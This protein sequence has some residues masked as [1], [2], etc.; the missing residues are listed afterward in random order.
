VVDLDELD[1]SDAEATKRE[2]ETFLDADGNMKPQ[3]H[4]T[5]SASDALGDME[6]SVTFEAVAADDALLATP[7]WEGLVHTTER[8]E[9]LRLRGRPRT[10]RGLS[11]AASE[12]LRMKHKEVVPAA[13]ASVPDF[14]PAFQGEK[15]TNMFFRDWT[16]HQ[17]EVSQ[18]RKHYSLQ[19]EEAM[20]SK[21]IR[22]KQQ[23]GDRRKARFDRQVDRR[24]HQYIRTKEVQ[25]AQKGQREEYA[26]QRLERATRA[27]EV[28]AQR[29][30]ERRTQ[31]CICVYVCMCVCVHV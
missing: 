13:D 18:V 27:K 9:S 14:D 7:E 12:A 1:L 25:S 2:V 8:L 26:K 22:V 5:F 10:A 15:R 31:V 23:L 24:M 17:R 28:A 11:M 30:Q 6:M 19:Y 3:V 21:Y 29:S 20:R 16:L 4:K